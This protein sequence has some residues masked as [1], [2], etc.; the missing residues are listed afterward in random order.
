MPAQSRLGDISAGH[1]CFPPTPII[2]NVTQTVYI[3]GIPAALLGSQL[4]PHACG[5]EVHAGG[6]RKIVSGS[7]SVFFEG[8]AP[9]RIG[10]SIA[11]GDCMAQGSGNVFVGG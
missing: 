1:A 2:S 4:A 5:R 6:L 9:A 11:D 3:N 7:S 10:D 8:K